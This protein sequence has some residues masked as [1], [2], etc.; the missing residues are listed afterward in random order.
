MRACYNDRKRRIDR[1][2]GGG[3]RSCMMTTQ[4]VGPAD[5]LREGYGGPPKLD[6][7]AEAGH[8]RSD[9]AGRQLMT[10]T[11]SRMTGTQS[12]DRLWDAVL[13]RDARGDGRFVYGVRSTRVYC[14]PSCPSRRPNRASV[15]FFPGPDAAEIAGFRAC[16]RCHPRAG[17]P[18]GRSIRRLRSL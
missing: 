15:R 18:P 9:D 12:D 14:R 5:R 4:N 6:A 13:S 2:G 8:Y 3:Y 10:G 1:P 16:R 17:A 11:Q 7:K